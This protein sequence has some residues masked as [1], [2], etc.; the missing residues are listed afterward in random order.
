MSYRPI[1]S[2]G[3][4]NMGMPRTTTR[5]KTLFSKNDR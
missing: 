4:L 5:V 1:D 3:I 2:I